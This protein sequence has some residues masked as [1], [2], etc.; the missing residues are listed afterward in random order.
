MDLNKKFADKTYSNDI[1][2]GLKATRLTTLKILAYADFNGE[3]LNADLFSK[4]YYDR[5]GN[6]ILATEFGY[7]QTAFDGDGYDSDTVVN[8]Y[9]ANTTLDSE[10]V[11]DSI[12][13]AG[14]DSNTFF[15]GYAGPS[16]PPE[17]VLF[18]AFEGLQFN[19]QS[20]SQSGG[21]NV[22]Y[23]MFL[24]LNGSVEY[25]RIADEFKTTLATAISKTD[26][27]IILTDAT[28][29]TLPF[30]GSKA[31]VIYIGDERITFGAIDGNVLKDVSRGT[32][33]T[34]VESH[35]AGT[36]VIDA[37]E[38]NRIEIGSQAFS[39]SNK[40]PEE[41]YWNEANVALA[42]STTTIARFLKDKPGSYFD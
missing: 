15:K 40:D 1:I 24:G 41:A 10:L 19:I 2:T 38:Q 9:M 7:D 13:Y 17:H 31:S 32:L 16:R 30:S 6:E 39:S 8:N 5:I 28:K 18:N 37:S 11:R 29:V 21:A 36:K 14:F 33:G 27:T 26:S 12:T 20:G 22:S 3:E 35:P 4:S 42:D 23:K 34:S 25:T